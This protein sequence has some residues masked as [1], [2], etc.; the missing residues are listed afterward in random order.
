MAEKKAEKKA[1]KGK[2]QS[3]GQ[4]TKPTGAVG[5]G[6][7]QN[8]APEPARPVEQSSPAPVPVIVNVGTD[9]ATDG[10]IEKLAKRV[11]DAPAHEKDRRLREVKAAIQ[12]ITEDETEQKTMLEKVNVE[13]AR[14]S[15]NK[16]ESLFSKITGGGFD[17]WTR[18]ILE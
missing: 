14:K 18:G 3:G 4:Q 1:G 7:F 12:T 17:K 9:R 16:T 15:E 6:F 5:L 11:I 13:I 2:R 8:R 10:L